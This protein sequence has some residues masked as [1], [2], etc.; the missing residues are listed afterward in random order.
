MA[1]PFIALADDRE[2][3]A[4]RARHMILTLSPGK[5]LEVS[6]GLV[7]KERTDPQNKALFGHAYKI[8]K[9][10]TGADIE[11]LHREFCIEFFGE[12]IDEVFGVTIRRP[13]RT[14]TTGPDGK[15]DV[16]EVSLFCEF[17]EHVR[18]VAAEYDVYIPDPDPRYHLWR[19]GVA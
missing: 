14:T 13:Y 18:R 5:D 17:F 11:Q 3:A 2:A 15:R 4:E 9:N 8:I 16:I 12:I 1:E 10:E 6:I 7:K 19:T